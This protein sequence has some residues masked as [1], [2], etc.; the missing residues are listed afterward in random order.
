MRTGNLRHPVTIQRQSTARDVVGQLVDTWTT[1][2]SRMASIEPLNGREY[3]GASGENS[4][5]STR[6]RMHW[7]A[8]AATVKPSDRVVHGLVQYDVLSVIVPR[9]HSREII[10]M[11]KRDG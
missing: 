10:L 6:I 8:V 5:V 4:D 3:F 11:A 1:L 2:C 9:E 7:D